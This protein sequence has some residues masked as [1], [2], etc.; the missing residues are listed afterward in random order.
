MEVYVDVSNN[1]SPVLNISLERLRNSYIRAILNDPI[2]DLSKINGY[3]LTY[4]KEENEYYVAFDQ[5]KYDEYL[6]QKEQEENINKG[7]A[8]LEN[9][10]E[11][12]ALKHATDEE[13]YIMRYLYDLWKADTKYEIG[14]RRLYKDTLYKCKQAH[15]SQ[16]QHTPDIVP[17]LW[18]IING[19]SKQGTIDNPIVVPEVMSSMEYE[20]GKYYLEGNKVYLCKR[21]G[22]PNP[23]SMYGQKVS[24]TFK[25]SQLVGH[26]FELVNK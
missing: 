13:A 1:S 12:L 22:V 16:A 17:A 24:L 18:D 2:V 21:G 23:E 5:K 8:L 14:D 7:N 4:K 25:P 6:K 26:Y 19:D 3:F 9:I 20:Y 10:Q 15:T 11:D